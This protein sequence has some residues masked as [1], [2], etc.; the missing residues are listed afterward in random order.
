M[1]W[2]LIITFFTAQTSTVNFQEFNKLSDCVEAAKHIEA[3]YQHSTKE[4]T[5]FLYV[6]CARKS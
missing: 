3:S 4:L 1:K 2:I 5:K 6:G